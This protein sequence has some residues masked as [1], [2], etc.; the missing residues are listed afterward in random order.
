MEQKLQEEE[1]TDKV[2][3]ANYEMKKFVITSDNIDKFR[4]LE[5]RRQIS[6]N[7]VKRI[8]G[9]L[10]NGNN[11]VGT[12]IVNQR[13]NEI[14]LIDGNHRIEALKRYFT[15]KKLYA[16]IKVE[17]MLKI[18]HG[19]SDEEERQVYADEA[20]RKN[21]TAEDRLNMFK[22][23]LVFW[24][25][26]NDRLNLFPCRVNIY[27]AKEGIRFRV[28]LDALLTVKTTSDIGYYPKY[29]A[30]D[31]LIDFCNDLT[32][33]DYLLIKEFISFFISVFG[34]IN[35]DNVFAKRHYFMPLFDIYTRNRE[36]KN[37]NNF[38]QRFH[39][40]FGKPEL[41]MYVNLGGREAQT[42][43]RSLMLEFMNFNFSR[44]QFI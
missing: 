9:A 22:D 44:N 33:N 32:H 23:T 37:L 1:K 18:Y 12:L 17:C 35:S 3:K 6:E 34:D 8:H 27:P 20:I 25:L 38:K 43:I 15:Y 41:M 24:K 4:I 28:I 13:N 2:R 14:R 21:E 11:P 42:R 30:K 40:V 16:K 36:Q 7:H 5:G 31:D 39:R 26:I 10:L 29:L 19:L